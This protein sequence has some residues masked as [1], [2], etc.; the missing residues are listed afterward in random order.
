MRQIFLVLFVMSLSGCVKTEKKEDSN[1]SKIS[2][3]HEN[4][5]KS[6]NDFMHESSTKELIERF[7]SKERDEY[8]KPELVLE[9]LGDLSKKT[10]IDIGAGSGYFTMKLARK[11]NKVIAA[12]VNDK[13]L[14]YIS[15]RTQSEKLEN[16]E[17]RKTPYDSP[18]I[19]N[20]EVDMI[21]L[22]NTYHH[23]E[24]RQA[25]F[26]K[27][28]EGLKPN[29]ELVIVDFFKK[30]TPVGPPMDHKISLE[31]V[32]QELKK[33]GFKD[34]EIEVDLLPYQYIIVAK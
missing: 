8:Q 6:A 20:K 7:E 21:F 12:D 10:I 23:I 28:K 32:T 31:N 9:Y 18:L 25:Y 2:L 1:E 15:K 16:I 3:N 26:E 4:H 19:K 13:F 34:F 29:G 5:K 17:L 24:N 11:A 14:E 30:E 33:V 22:A 27:A